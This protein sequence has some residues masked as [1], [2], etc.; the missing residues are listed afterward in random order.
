MGLMRKAEEALTG[1]HNESTHSSN[2]GPH[3]SN[4]VNKLDPRVDSDRGM[5]SFS[6]SFLPSNSITDVS[7][8]QITESATS[9]WAVLQALTPLTLQT[10]STLVSTVTGVCL[11]L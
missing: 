11:L 3:N 6:S 7:H 10:N 1:H 2:H 4:I 9:T 5:L 8:E